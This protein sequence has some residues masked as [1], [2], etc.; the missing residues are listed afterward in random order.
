MVDDVLRR[1]HLPPLRGRSFSSEG[2]GED[3][4]YDASRWVRKAEDGCRVRTGLWHCAASVSSLTLAPS[5]TCPTCVFGTGE[6]GQ[7]GVVLGPP[8]PC[9]CAGAPAETGWHQGQKTML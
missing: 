4:L 7:A 9:A 1:C 5:S 8:W 2:T 3:G 6:S